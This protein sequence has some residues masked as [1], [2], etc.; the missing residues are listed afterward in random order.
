MSDKNLNNLT[1][2]SSAEKLPV[3]FYPTNNCNYQC[4]TPY[5]TIFCDHQYNHNKANFKDLI[6]IFKLFKS[7][8]LTEIAKISGREPT[9][10]P[11]LINLV[12]G[13]SKVAGKITLSTNGYENHEKIYNVIKNG[14]SLITISV[15]TLNHK[16]YGFFTGLPKE[17][18]KKSLKNV[19]NLIENLSNYDVELHFIRILLKDFNDSIED[20]NRFID[21]SKKYDATMKIFDLNYHPML[22]FPI[23]NQTI[24]ISSE[25][26]WKNLYVPTDQWREKFLA[27]SI[28]K[29]DFLNSFSCRK[30]TL[31]SLKN[32]IKV[33]MDDFL[34][35]KK[36]RFDHCRNCKYLSY[37]R[38]GPFSNGWELR[39]NLLLQICPLRDDL[40]LDLRNPKKIQK[41]KFKGGKLKVER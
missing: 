26:I 3:R 33:L 11:E 39:P 7:E 8:N 31:M 12:K 30:V 28:N 6:Q 24:N 40:T 14:V 25:T 13:L 20:M 9:L 37:C 27:D 32:G 1:N 29:I 2:F 17:K 41:L 35:E 23:G 34:E 38:E 18:A 10:Y 22:N 36:K 16:R 19:L 4:R 15:P 5:S 21:F